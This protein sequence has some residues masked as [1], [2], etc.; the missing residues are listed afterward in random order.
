MRG[1]LLGR[2]FDRG[3]ILGVGQTRASSAAATAAAS[4]FAAQTTTDGPGAGERDA[5]RAGHRVVAQ[6]A[7]A[8][9]RPRRGTA[10]A[11]CR[12]TRPRAGRRRPAATA[13]PSSAACALAAA[14]S[15]C[16]TDAGRRPREASVFTRVSGTTTIGASG[17]SVASRR[18]CVRPVP[19]RQL[20]QTPP[21]TAGARLSAWPSSGSPSASTSSGEAVA[22]GDREAGDEAA[23]DRGG[24]RA[25][26][27]LERDAVHEAE[28]QSL[29]RRDERERA[30]REV[31]G[32]PRQLVGALALEHDL[33]RRSPGVDLELVPEVERR[34]EAVEARPEV[35]RRR[36]R[37]DDVRSC[38][39][40]PC[41]ARTRCPSITSPIDRFSHASGT[42]QT[43]MPAKSAKA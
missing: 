3:R 37:A 43:S 19:L 23:R 33:A 2:R 17:R 30:Q 24:G 1:R 10:R 31:L 14:A 41:A 21:K 8:A 36:R 25:E 15:A 29:D 34:A 7:R 13:A 26:P 18:V 39:P 9:A 6:L 38:A 4:A 20:R 40:A 11:A 28:A 5:G 12:G 27:A 16:E 32:A 35:R 42:R 22:P